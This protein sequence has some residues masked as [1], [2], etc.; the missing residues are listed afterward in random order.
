MATQHVRTAPA[1]VG[2]ATRVSLVVVG[3]GLLLSLLARDAVTAAGPVLLGLAALA[4]LPHG[5]ADVTLIGRGLRPLMTYA[6]AAALALGVALAFPGPALVV[7]LVLSV[8]HFAEGEQA[9]DRLRGG[10]GR[11]VPAL[12][13]GWS[14]IALPVGLHPDAV[15][16]LLTDLDPGVASAVLSP[17]GRVALVGPAAVLVALALGR[18]DTRLRLEIALGVALLAVA[19][20]LVGF[21]VWFAG[22]HA[23]RH[24]A[25]VVAEDPDG[26]GVLGLLRATAWPSLV[27]AAG[28]AALV[29]V[30]GTVP[31]AVVLGLLALTVPHAVVVV[32]ELRPA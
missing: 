13:V 9:F 14:T 29:V 4:G 8:A 31:P 11:L 22:W 25:R 27:A 21:A 24:M 7:L 17:A 3:A 10:A 30:A 6:L 2:T 28:I 23:V 18:A 16:G 19:P 20:P 32:R 1:A 26:P 12:A 15:R 5:A